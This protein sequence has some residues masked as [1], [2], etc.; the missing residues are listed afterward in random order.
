MNRPNPAVL[1]GFFVA[2][3]VAMC[4]LTLL[5]GGLYLSRH[6]GDT[7][8]LMQVLLRMDGGQRPHLD[9]MTP[10]GALSFAPIVLF[11]QMGL[12]VG[13]S[14]V[15]A[16]G[17][18]A[19]V[20]LP[21]V[22]WVAFSRMRGALA[23]LF[24]LIVLVLVTALVHGEA[25]SA[26]SV[27]MYYNRWAWAI[28]FVV[29]AA[30]ILPD[31]R[32][33]R[34]SV[35]GVVIGAGMAALVLIKM[36]FFVAFCLPVLAALILRARYRV[37]AVSVGV[38]AMVAL[39]VTAIAGLEFWTAYLGDLLA[40]AG[41][42]IR[43]YP[44]EPI[45]VV[46]GAPANIAGSLVLIGAV[47]LLRQA[48]E[49]VGGLVL[50]LLVPGFFFVTYQN[51][52]NDPQWLMLL[53]VLLIALA[54]DRDLRNGFGWDMRN[55]LK[56]AGA[57][58]FALGAPSFLN[59]AYSPY[60]H[61]TVDA[62]EYSPVL[63]NNALHSDIHA[64]NLRAFRT[65]ATVALDEMHVG[66]DQFNDQ[67]MRSE[68][69]VFQGETLPRCELL[70]GMIAWFQTVADDLT[71]AGY[72]QGKNLFSADILSSEW[73]FNDALQP[74]PQGAPWYYGDLSGLDAA[75]YLLVPLCPIEPEARR[76]ILVDVSADIL[77]ANF[78]VDEVRRTGLY[79]LYDI[80]AVSN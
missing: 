49:A 40:V 69:T 17:L 78:A 63:A 16:Q 67:A 27:S 45:G 23:Y 76:R 48:R 29:I 50:L 59:L 3:I 56:I 41:S 43:P 73:M 57:V 14:I 36:T 28:S 70:G 46:V 10:I 75:D 4:G 71:D 24:G 79:I 62:A 9:F 53:A 18:V 22:W 39:T 30:A 54:P 2:I 34:S 51:F 15:L 6:E 7:L 21:V 5:K 1:F 25:L 77:A 64:P 65:S 66:L 60:R 52:G 68:A 19:I 55:A 32:A 20:L 80:A 61:Y 11:M 35:D 47:M 12:G 38:A 8:H 72:A 44:G 58:A 37:I 31:L 42:D 74:L 13:K 33:P 26:I